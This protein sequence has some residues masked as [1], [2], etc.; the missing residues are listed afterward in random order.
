MG[1]L[2]EENSYQNIIEPLR[3]LMFFEKRRED[4]H[5]VGEQ[6]LVFRHCGTIKEL[7]EKF[8]L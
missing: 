8:V 2:L 1:N 6:K 3:Q 4:N 7:K 5:S